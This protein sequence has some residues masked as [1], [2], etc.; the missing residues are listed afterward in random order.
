M[1]TTSVRQ[2]LLC[3]VFLLG[4]LLGATVLAQ[5][6]PTIPDSSGSDTNT[7]GTNTVDWTAFYSNNLA[8]VSQWVH[9]PY[10]M[11]DGS[12]AGFQMVMDTTASNFAAANTTDW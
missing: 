9:Y 4:T 8:A 1:K 11:P 6:P 12:F 10:T 7:V 5:G 3:G 2:W